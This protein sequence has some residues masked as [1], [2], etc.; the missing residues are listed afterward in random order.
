M[1]RIIYYSFV[2][3]FMSFSPFFQKKK[4]KHIKNRKKATEGTAKENEKN[5]I[6]SE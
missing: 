1:F 4:A 3:H 5:S 6:K 2:F